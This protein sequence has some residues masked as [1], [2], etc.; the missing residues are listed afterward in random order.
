MGRLRTGANA[1]LPPGLLARQRPSGTHYFLSRP[2]DGKREEVPL[3]KVLE[4]ALA[5]Y[6]SLVPGADWPAW[7]Q[8]AVAR[9]LFARAR[10]GARQRRLEFAIELQHVEELLAQ[11][12][13]RCMLTGIPFDMRR[14]AG[15]RKR[16]WAPSVDRIES[17][18]GYVLGNVRLVAIAVN[19]AMS[20]F[21]EEF[22]IRIANALSRR[23]H[24]KRAA[25]RKSA[26]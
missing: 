5:E 14:P 25:L 20:D 2:K 7:D 15:A 16:L 23:Q 18:H 22:L 13:G 10:K 9:E 19:I 12:D 8:A 3:G 1:T 4:H 26:E 21:G 17:A 6:R 11:A 24:D